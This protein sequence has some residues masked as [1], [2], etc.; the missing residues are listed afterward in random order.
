M[1]EKLAIM[2]GK[3]SCLGFR[4]VGMDAYIANVPEDA[5]ALWE[6]IPQADYAVIFV[7][8]P[9]Y[10]VLAR[11]EHDW[12]PRDEPVVIV[13]PAVAGSCGSGAAMVKGMVE[14]AVGADIVMYE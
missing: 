10:E 11:S 3:T 1:G 4:A 14:K 9:L 12:P 8:E 2:G 5:P 7:T 6:T 13:I